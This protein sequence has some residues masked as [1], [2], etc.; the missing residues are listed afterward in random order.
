MSFDLERLFSL[1]PAVYRNRDAELAERA[2]IP[3]GPLEALLSLIA[4]QVAVLEDDLAQLYDD[5][6]IETC[7]EWVVPYIGDLVGA[8]GL[9]VFTNTPFSQRALVANTVAARRRK[10]T[11]AALEEVARDAGGWNTY[12]AEYFSRLGTTQFMNHV[13]PE[14]LIMP[15]L[16]DGATLRAIGTPFDPVARTFEARRIQTARGRYNIPNIGVHVWRLQPFAVTGAP[17]FMVDAHRFLFDP[18]GR[19]R[20]LITNPEPE[21]GISHRATPINVPEP[22]AR[23]TLH[24]DVQPTGGGVYY[25]QQKSVLLVV[26]DRVIPAAEI[27]VC[28][29]VDIGYDRWAREPA[30]SS[31]LIDPELGRLVTKQSEPDADVRVSYQYTFSAPIGGGEY[32]R[33]RT[34]SADLSP[35]F[36]VSAPASI[37]SA[38]DTAGGRGAVEIEGSG[39]FVEA[40]LVEAAGNTTLEL[41]AAD[42]TR[43]TVYLTGAMTVGG[44]VDAEVTLNG[45]WIV[46]G[47]LRVPRELGPQ[48]PN[49]LRTLRL[50]HCTLVPGPIPPLRLP[51]GGP[52][53][54]VPAQVLAPRLH[55]DLPGVVVEI[56]QCIVAGV[57]AV[58]G[59][60]VRITNSII[61][62]GAASDV[63]Y[64]GLLDD[65]AGARMTAINTTVIGKV[66]SE[67]IELASNTIFFSELARWDWWEGPVIAERLQQGCVRFSYVPPR[68]RVPRRYRCQPS[69]A[70]ADGRIRP[71]FTSLDWSDPGYCQLSGHTTPE[72]TEGADDQSEMGAFHDVYQ[73]QRLAN[74]RAR[75]DE[76]LRFGL[77]GG[78]L[79]AS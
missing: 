77:E 62:A 11:T 37:Q 2:G 67:L 21:T 9:F 48:Q 17:A 22:I 35:V 51:G 45:L 73:P 72:I 61:D 32:A 30:V 46:G 58:A 27:R 41:R 60:R 24:D 19:D 14:N 71:V 53:P 12:V 63:A 16:R 57:R 25:G 33:Q 66:R 8:R 3:E 31:Y 75:I 44:G 40:P 1:L 13:R 18:G 78:T 70:A 79:F 5:Q 69:S 56:D 15:N 38:L 74:V 26:N 55:V 76:Y 47:L 10:G 43:P 65:D 52:V 42:N 49:G 68:S 23:A 6:F 20:R 28:N 64:A 50:R 36:T 7:A 59:A 29:L 4:E 54:A 39:R 34:F